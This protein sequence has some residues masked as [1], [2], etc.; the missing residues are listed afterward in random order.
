[1]G[2]A[3]RLEALQKASILFVLQPL[4]WKRPESQTLSS[5]STLIH[6]KDMY[7]M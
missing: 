2:S 1:L 5:I 4:L 3:F 7:G 6:R